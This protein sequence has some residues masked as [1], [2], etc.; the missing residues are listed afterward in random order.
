MTAI[1]G[2]RR[3]PRD[4]MKKDADHYYKR[5]HE[6]K[7]LEDAIKLREEIGE[8]LQSDAPAKEKELVLGRGECLH[9]L[10]TSFKRKRSK[11]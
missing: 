10:I 2:N 11:Q 9:K 5:L 4:E 1:P 7:S 8:F 6:I 3:G